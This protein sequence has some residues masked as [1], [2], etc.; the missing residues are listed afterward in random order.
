[1]GC[2]LFCH[3]Y[4]AIGPAIL[5]LTILQIKAISLVFRKKRTRFILRFTNIRDFLYVDR[6]LEKNT[7]LIVLINPI[8]CRYKIQIQGL[9]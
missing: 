3:K 2:T 8:L 4:I 9:K 7:V 1:M 5:L 6:T